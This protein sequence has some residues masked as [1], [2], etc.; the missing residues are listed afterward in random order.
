M[1]ETIKCWRK[2]NGILPEDFSESVRSSWWDNPFFEGWGGPS[3]TSEYNCSTL[4]Y[5]WKI[6]GNIWGGECD[7]RE[8][9]AR[10]IVKLTTGVAWPIRLVTVVILEGCC[11][12]TTKGGTVGRLAEITDGLGVLRDD[13]EEEEDDNEE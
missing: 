10:S 1:L 11:C 5:C 12:A 2:Y 7:G 4:G 8:G 6:A 13:D 3:Y 9:G